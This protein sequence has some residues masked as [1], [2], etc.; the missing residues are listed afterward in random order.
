VVL[1][2]PADTPDATPDRAV[3]GRRISGLV[4]SFVSS[5]V[6][7]IPQK[8]KLSELTSPHFEQT[9][10]FLPDVFPYSLTPDSKVIAPA[11]SY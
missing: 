7:H 10:I 6:P 4:S 1:D 8:R 9:T 11:A 5:K 3:T 2:A